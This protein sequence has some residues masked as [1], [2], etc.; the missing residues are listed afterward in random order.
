[1]RHLKL[2]GRVYFFRTCDGLLSVGRK[3]TKKK[4]MANVNPVKRSKNLIV[5]KRDQKLLSQEMERK[6]NLFVKAATRP[7]LLWTFETTQ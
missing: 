2:S 7:I 6:R 3:Q 1:V 5:A 4:T